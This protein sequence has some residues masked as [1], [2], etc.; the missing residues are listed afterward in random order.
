MIEIKVMKTKT[1]LE[2]CFELDFNYVEYYPREIEH[3]EMRSCYQYYTWLF[4]KHE[5]FTA[6]SKGKGLIYSIQWECRLLDIPFTM[7]YDEDY[8]IVHFS[9][10]E[11]RISDIHTIAAEIR[12][13]IEL[14]ADK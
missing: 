11:D 14:E 1:G 10:D 4:K 7:I 9:V 2:N 6:G 3:K 8:D 5:I 13:L 12:R